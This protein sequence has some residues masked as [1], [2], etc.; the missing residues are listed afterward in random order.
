MN[1]HTMRL[2]IAGLIAPLTLAVAASAQ[3]IG[4]PEI[5]KQSQECID[6]HKKESRAIY[7]MWGASKHY[8]ANVG[9]YECHKAEKSD[10]DALEHHEATISII[11]S[12]KDCGKCHEREVKE[13]VG[14]H[15]SKGGRILGSLDNILAEIVEGNRAF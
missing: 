12:P 3:A 4:L 8:R 10:P 15:H 6:C 2:G 5:S 9:C 14:S 1:R 13:F 11:V 7:Q